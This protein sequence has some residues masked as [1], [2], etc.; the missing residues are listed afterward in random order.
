MYS[1]A[2]TAVKTQDEHRGTVATC[3]ARATRS[4][5]A[6]SGATQVFEARPATVVQDLPAPDDAVR[7]GVRALWRGDRRRGR[8]APASPIVPGI[9]TL[10]ERGDFGVLSFA[11]PDT[12][13]AIL[14]LSEPDGSPRGWYVNLQTPLA[15]HLDRVRH[16][17]SPARRLDPDRSLVVGMEGRGRTRRRHRARTLHRSRRR[18]VPLLGR[19]RGRTSVP[20]AA[21]VR[22]GLGGLAARSDVARAGAPARLG[23]RLIRAGRDSVSPADYPSGFDL[24][25]GAPHE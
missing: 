17:R 9:C 11:W 16:R 12:P 13:Y 3:G 10:R 18:L 6:R 22:R 4:C 20:A 21:A 14:L 1:R 15:A 25:K 2:P 7:G 5:S 8:R 23:R 19:A 24:V